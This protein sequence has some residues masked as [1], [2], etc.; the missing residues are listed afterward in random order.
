VFG[1][2]EYKTPIE[3]LT[4]KLEYSSDTYKQEKILIGK[5]YSFPLNAGLSYRPFPW[6]DV[7]LSWMHGRYASFRIST[8][9]DATA[10]NWA[11][12]LD[13]APRFRAR[14]AEAAPTLLQHNGPVE[15]SGAP[16]TRFVDL[17]AER[18][19]PA[20][21]IVAEPPN[22]PPPNASTGIAAS[23]PVPTIVPPAT[24]APAPAEGALDAN[25]EMVIRQGL[26]T[27]ELPILGLGR[28][29]PKLVILVENNHYRRD[30]EAIARVARVLSAAAP[31][32]LDY[33]E[34]TLMHVGQ[35]FTTVTLPRTQIDKL[36]QQTGSPAELFEATDIAPG[37]PGAL[38][39]I[40]PGLFPDVNTYL[41]PVFRQSLFD[42]DNPVYVR[43]GIGGSAGLRLTRGLFIEGMVI[44]SLYDNFGQIKRETNS[45]LPHVRSD[46]PHYL[47]EGKFEIANLLSSYFFKFAPEIY[48]RVSAGYL[49]EMFAGFGG[50]LLYRPFGQRWAIGVDLWAVRQRDFNVL[51]GLR[52]YSAITGHISAYYELPWHDVRVA[53]SAGQYLAGDKGVTFE[54][55][56][57]F[58]TG[59]QIGAWFTL[60]NVSAERFGE[61]SFDKGIRI[62]IPFEWAAPFAT[63]TSYDL[64]LRSIQRDG[65][66]KLTGDTFLYGLTDASSYG[67]LLQEWNSVFR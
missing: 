15:E 30:S 9:I 52:N 39:H 45:V 56:R 8:L 24:S 26:A 65:G 6:L 25:A 5:D 67:T 34:I 27:Q 14:P 51:F 4:V 3:N 44:Q 63:Q 46:F 16:A 23:P 40:Q 10:E 55:F 22:P 59:V 29:G 2:I 64:A 13:P 17:T 66:Q 49:E 61:G 60:T 37:R 58:S 32:N 54:L 53:V 1:G 18:Q 21:P 41:F 43:F 33:F 12:R 35:P 19:T 38:D 62:I 47:Q 42:P 7:G 48:G 57:K 50:E 11:S 28:E 31:P 36:A 20:P